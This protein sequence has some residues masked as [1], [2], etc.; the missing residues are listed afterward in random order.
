MRYRVRFQNAERTGYVYIRVW[1]DSKVRAYWEADTQVRE[2]GIPIYT[3]ATRHVTALH[4]ETVK[5][6]KAEVA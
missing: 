6:R 3:P 5:A 1:A 4:A 2:D